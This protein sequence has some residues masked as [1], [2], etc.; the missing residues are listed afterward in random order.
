[1]KIVE[2]IILGIVQGLTEFLPVSSSGHLAIV[3]SVMGVDLEGN[4]FMNVML[5]IGTLA[6]VIICYRS[7][8]GKLIRE[9][10]LMLKDIFTGK[11]SFKKMNDSRNMIIMLIIGLL[12]L[13]L[14]F[15]PLPFANGVKLKDLADVFGTSEYLW[16]V[17]ASLILTSVFLTLGIFFNRRNL[18]HN[19]LRTRYNVLD[20]LV[21]GIAQCFAAVLSGFS[22]SGSTL[23][24]AQM[25]GIDK[26]SALD[27]S[28]IIGIPS[29]FAAAV[30][31]IKDAV[32][33]DANPVNTIGILP[34][35]IGIVVSAAVGIGA[36]KLFKWMLAKDRT[37]IFAIYTAAMGLATV[38]YSFVR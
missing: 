18:L 10:F 22:R 6:A 19:K 36:I 16:L 7:L 23:A 30:L 24:T 4:L 3:K 31:E 5:H 37:Y 15:I 32:T 12:P 17:G 38:V 25:R 26:Q 2:A 29:I 14:L 11:F 13:F 34:I 9:F 33:A 28:F 1:M 35:I 20:A 8:V 27:Y 21:V